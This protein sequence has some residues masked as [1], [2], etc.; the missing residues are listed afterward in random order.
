MEKVKKSVK[1]LGRFLDVVSTASFAASSALEPDPSLRVLSTGLST[2]QGFE[3][4]S[5]LNEDK[6]YTGNFN[7]GVTLSYAGLGTIFLVK[8]IYDALGGELGRIPSD[9]GLSVGSYTNVL[10][11]NLHSLASKIKN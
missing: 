2:F 5:R 9:I 1:N 3:T 11:R 10:S 6:E 7:K 8:S 4:G